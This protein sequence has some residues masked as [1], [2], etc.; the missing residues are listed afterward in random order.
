MHHL[1]D[2]NLIT[3]N[4]NQNLKDK[5]H[6]STIR[7]MNLN[8]T[9]DDKITDQNVE[10]KIYDADTLLN[11]VIQSLINYDDVIKFIKL[12]NIIGLNE[13]LKQISGMVF[14]FKDL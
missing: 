1:K 13:Y 7:E 9:A 2:L 11:K 5:D 10:D 14:N 6:D 4:Q 3:N 8:E 12:D